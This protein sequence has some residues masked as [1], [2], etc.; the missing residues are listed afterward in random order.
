MM[1][2]VSELVIGPKKVS[3]IE[4]KTQP[5]GPLCL[6]QC[7]FVAIVVEIRRSIEG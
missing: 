7:F 4:S 6:W 2:F 5:S 3:L 1:K